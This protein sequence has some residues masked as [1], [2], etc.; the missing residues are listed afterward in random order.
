MRAG[1]TGH[2]DFRQTVGGEE[3]FE[4]LFK[5]NQ[6]SRV[7]IGDEKIP[8]PR[9]D[10]DAAQPERGQGERRPGGRLAVQGGNTDVGLGG[11]VRAGRH[12]RGLEETV[13]GGCVRAIAADL[14]GLRRGRPGE[15]GHDA[16]KRQYGDRADRPQTG[17]A[18]RPVMNAWAPKIRNSAPAGIVRD[19]W[20]M[21]GKSGPS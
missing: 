6:V 14:L 20:S 7:S 19:L 1:S 11:A 17:V 13:L 16:G 10:G 9:L 2:I 21:N 4:V 8:T 12:R 3:A 15:P 18:I 5:N